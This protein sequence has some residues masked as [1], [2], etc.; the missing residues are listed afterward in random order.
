MLKLPVY[1]RKHTYYFHTRIAGRQYKRSLH[2]SD[3]LLA[4]LRAVEFL[5]V[6]DMNKP[7]V[8]DFNELNNS[9]LSRYELDLVKGIAK[10]E[11]PEDHKRLMQA[12]KVMAKATQKTQPAAGFEPL[13]LSSA[14][15]GLT[16]PLLAERFFA[17]KSTLSQAT[18]TDY[19]ATAKEFSDHLKNPL[20]SEVTEDNVTGY[21]DWLASRKNTPRTIDK[22]VGAVRA[23][24]NFAIKQKILKGQNP[25]ADRNL[26][27]KKEKKAS[28][29]RAFDL[30]DIK[31]LF[32][33]DS[34]RGYKTTE[35]AFYWIALTGLITGIRVS[36]LAGITKNSFKVSPKGC[37]YLF[38][39]DD[40]TPAGTRPVPLPRE[41]YVPLFT[42][43]RD[44]KGF[45][46]VSRD[47]GK[48]A[49]DPVR[50]L[51]ELHKKAIGFSGE[52][53]TFHSL[54]KTLNNV[55]MHEKVPIEARCQII[56]HEISHVNVDIYSTEYSVDELGE[57]VIPCQKDLLQ[58]VLFKP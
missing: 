55:L 48:G 25:A 14:S 53:Q 50:K 5:R 51:L 7:K 56:G 4:T 34:F 10:A 20:I 2:T 45:G 8:S 21:M 35:P 12:L 39:G 27:T 6:I 17:M 41:F 49:S 3:P 33:N 43:V 28:G 58:L 44:N 37:H 40:K 23:L 1:I 9:S 52:G 42:F 19:K 26:L 13:A 30:A 32:D 18:K 15:A 11:N 36:A 46:F 22:K 57:M 16:L 24:Y 47:D 54:R 29:S 38:I 31:S